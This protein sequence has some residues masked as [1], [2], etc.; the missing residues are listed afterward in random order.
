M[1]GLARR[2]P[3]GLR[4]GVLLRV[5]GQP[6]QDAGRDQRAPRAAVPGHAAGASTRRRPARTRSS[7]T[8]CRRTSARRSAPSGPTCCSRRRRRARSRS[9]SRAP[10]PAKARAWSP[11]TSPSRSRRPASACCSSTPTCA[12]RG[13]TR[14]FGVPQEP[15]LSNL[16]V[17]NAKASEAVRKTSVPSLWVIA[18]RPHS[19]Q[20]GGA[21]RLG[22]D[23]ATSSRRS[24]STSTGSSSTRRRSWR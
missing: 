9:W 2:R 13:P 24:S 3:A 14:F 12:S 15:G 18:G 8:A 21:P 10:G 16:L 1:L 7:A 17:G 20:P 5:P 23:S 4:A 6:D 19:P 11:A 22:S